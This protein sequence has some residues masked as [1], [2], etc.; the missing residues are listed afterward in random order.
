MIWWDDLVIPVQDWDD[1][2]I[3]VRDLVIPVRELA[4]AA[5]RA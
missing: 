1:L 3:P 4:S 2:V 5:S